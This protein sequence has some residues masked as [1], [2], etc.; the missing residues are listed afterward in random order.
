MRIGQKIPKDHQAKGKGSRQEFLPSR[1][2]M[3]KLTG[4]SPLDRSMN[5]YARRTPTGA[6][7]PATYQDI[8][9]MGEK[10]IDLKE[11]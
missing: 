5:E 4:G 9:Q 3:S 7:A 6:G 10:G 11:V 8:E 1:F 2:A